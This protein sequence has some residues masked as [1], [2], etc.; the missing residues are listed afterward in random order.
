MLRIFVEVQS[1]KNVLS[2]SLDASL[3]FSHYKLKIPEGT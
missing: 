1:K 2:M 3:Q